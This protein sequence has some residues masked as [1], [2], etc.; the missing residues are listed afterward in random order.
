MALNFDLC[1]IC[2]QK[3][4][5]RLRSPFDNPT[6][7]VEITYKTYETFVARV[8]QFCDIEQ[9]PINIKLGSDISAQIL[10]DAKA[11][12]HSSCFQNYSAAKLSRTLSRSSTESEKET[13]SS[14]WYE[15]Y[16]L[17]MFSKYQ[18]VESQ[19]TLI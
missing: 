13:A 19:K 6:G 15:N 1:I 18:I 2:Q 8:S 3:T 16:Y 12:W 14:Q 17:V 7:T 11:Q 5:E 4:D 9:F 10:F